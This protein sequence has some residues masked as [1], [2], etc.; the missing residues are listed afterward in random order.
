M[1]VDELL[2]D[3][4]EVVWGSQQAGSGL[5]FELLRARGIFFK[6]LSIAEARPSSCR[7]F[8]VSG[9]LGVASMA[10]PSAASL[11]Q[12]LVPS[13]GL[14]RVVLLC[15]EAR[16]ITQLKNKRNTPFLWGYFTTGSVSLVVRGYGYGVG[17]RRGVRDDLRWWELVCCCQW[18]MAFHLYS[19]KPCDLPNPETELGQIKFSCI[20]LVGIILIWILCFTMWLHEG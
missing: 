15:E 19:P 5:D 18:N 7:H 9:S 10:V 14:P 17:T 20:F 3:P 6:N 16:G 8:A 1:N 4:W 2:W 12:L 13:P 11:P